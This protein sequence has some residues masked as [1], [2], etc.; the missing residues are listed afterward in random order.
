M[1]THFKLSLKHL[2]I[3]LKQT[4][5]QVSV[6]LADISAQHLRGRY[7]PEQ[8]PLYPP[9]QGVCLIH[10]KALPKGLTAA[11]SSHCHW[12]AHPQIVSRTG[13]R[14]WPYSA[15]G[16]DFKSWNLSMISM[17]SQRKCIS[18]V[19]ITNFSLSP[20]LQMLSKPAP[21]HTEKLHGASNN[22]RTHKSS[23]SALTTDHLRWKS[24]VLWGFYPRNCLC[25]CSSAS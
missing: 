19:R 8:I 18:R 16:H 2:K 9:A 21:G 10:S 3:V 6:R 23:F 25:T 4:C 17:K 13:K 5:S 12:C 7:L 22:S 1:P 20:P 11:V 14:P 24:S 15:D